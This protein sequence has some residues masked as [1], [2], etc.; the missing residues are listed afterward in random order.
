MRDDFYPWTIHPSTLCTATL[1]N[2]RI[3]RRLRTM[4]FSLS[5]PLVARCP[6][7]THGNRRCPKARSIQPSGKRLR[8]SVLC[9]PRSACGDSWHRNPK[10]QNEESPV[11]G[12]R[13]IAP[14]RLRTPSILRT[15][16]EDLPG[17]DPDESA[18]VPELI[19]RAS[20]AGSSSK[21]NCP[22]TPVP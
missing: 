18:L 8:S 19:Q 3:G 22:S 10:R 9:R 2:W 7:E 5:T 1:E 4:L 16:I 15:G 20:F 6:T 21:T 13:A 14:I 11:Q 12:G 17:P